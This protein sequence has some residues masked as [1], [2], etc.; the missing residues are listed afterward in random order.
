MRDTVLRK[1]KMLVKGTN[2]PPR[3]IL[4]SLATPGDAES[5]VYQLFM[6]VPYRS[7]RK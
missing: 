2:G 6:Q 3:V 5:L 1:A 4:G 7:L